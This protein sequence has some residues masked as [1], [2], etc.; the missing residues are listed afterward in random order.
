MRERETDLDPEVLRAEVNDGEDAKLVLEN[1]LIVRLL[2]IAR[3]KFTEAALSPGV[4][5]E[6]AEDLRREFFALDALPAL[7]RR[8]VET[9]Q[10]AAQTLRETTRDTDA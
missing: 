4:K 1:A 10:M 3:E 6:A 5:A 2:A 7:L 9:G 8:Y